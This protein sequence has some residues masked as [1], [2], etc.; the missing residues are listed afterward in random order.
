MLSTTSTIEAYLPVP[1]FGSSFFFVVPRPTDKPYEA[2]IDDRSDAEKVT[3][4][5]CLN[6]PR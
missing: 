6:M 1:A 4:I 5:D 2:A 3:S